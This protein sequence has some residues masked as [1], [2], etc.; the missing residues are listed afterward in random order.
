MT[1]YNILIID[2]SSLVSQHQVKLAARQVSVIDVQI[3][4]FCLAQMPV[5]LAGLSCLITN[6]FAN[7]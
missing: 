3:D 6:S 7:S 2:G 5:A 4:M 1:L